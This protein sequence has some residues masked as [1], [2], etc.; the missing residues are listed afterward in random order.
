MLQKCSTLGTAPTARWVSWGTPC[1]KN[2]FIGGPSTAKLGL[3]GGGGC[4]KNRFIGGYCAG[5]GRGL[6]DPHAAKKMGLSGDPL[7]QNWGC[8]GT[9]C[10]KKWV[11]WWILCCKNVFLVGPQPRVLGGTQRCKNGCLRGA[12]GAKNGSVGGPC[13]TKISFLEDPTLQKK[14]TGLLGDPALQK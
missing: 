4:W 12:H 10:C 9:P 11:L 6:R 14:K 5:K 2:S 1:W 8:W 13:N 3:L 7:V